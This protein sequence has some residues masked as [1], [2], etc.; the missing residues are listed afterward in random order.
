[1]CFQITASPSS[2]C[3]F[4]STAP[5]SENAQRK[6]SSPGLVSQSGSQET[7]VLRGVMEPWKGNAR[8]C[9]PHCILREDYESRIS[10][11]EL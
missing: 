4:A 5:A 6:L 9:S 1:M 10:T 11:T 2:V 7:G 3:G 8:S